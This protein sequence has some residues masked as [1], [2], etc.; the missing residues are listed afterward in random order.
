MTLCTLVVGADGARRA[1]AIVARLELRVATAVILEG[2][3]PGA[4]VLDVVA[5][6]PHGASLKVVTIAAGC[7]CCGDGRV[8][9]VTLNRMLQ[10]RPAQLFISLAD[11][12]HLPHLQQFLCTPPYAAL[13]SL[14]AVVSCDS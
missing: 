14:A 7:P 6:D 4:G 2:I 13:L 9:R 5:H 8:M 12:N 10:R 3:D 11:R 1:A